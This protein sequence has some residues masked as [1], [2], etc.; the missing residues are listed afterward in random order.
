[1]PET[2]RSNVIVVTGTDSGAGKTWVTAALAR[3]LDAL[4]ARV[5]AI[6]AVD[7]GCREDQRDSE[8]GVVLARATGQAAPT[9]ALRRLSYLPQG[10][11]F[12]PHPR[13]RVGRGAIVTQRCRAARQ[14]AEY[15]ASRTR[16]RS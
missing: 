6:K 2:R 11:R 5:V 7:I 16:R 12:H 9:E 1:M 8:D 14:I 13:L 4:G 3:A 10:P 15:R